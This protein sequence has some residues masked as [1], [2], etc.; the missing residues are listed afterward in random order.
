[1]NAASPS[2]LQHS[3]NTLAAVIGHVRSGSGAAREGSNSGASRMS[4]SGGRGGRLAHER[5]RT[6]RRHRCG[7]ARAHASFLQEPPSRHRS[8]LLRGHD[9]PPA[10]KQTR[11]TGKAHSYTTAGPI[12]VVHVELVLIHPFREGNGRLSRLRT[13]GRH[14]RLSADDRSG[15]ASVTR[16][17]KELRYLILSSISRTGLPVSIA[18][19]LATLRIRWRVAFSVSRRCGFVSA[20][21]FP[22]MPS[23]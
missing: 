5:G 20:S 6:G 18:V 22:F 19:E 16:G 4:A 1:M 9:A 17:R 7:R 13:S 8:L 11:R 10:T 3:A 14:E 2:A 21:V 12:A 15:Q 23:L